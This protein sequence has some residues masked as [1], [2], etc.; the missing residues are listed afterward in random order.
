MQGREHLVH[1]ANGATDDLHAS[2]L[3]L[4]QLPNVLLDAVVIGHKLLHEIRQT[5]TLAL[6]PLHVLL[7]VRLVLNL[8]RQAP[9][10]LSDLLVLELPSP[11]FRID[12]RG[13]CL[14]ALHPRLEGEE[15]RTEG[16]TLTLE[17]RRGPLH[18]QEPLVLASEVAQ[19]LL[20][21][22]EALLQPRLLRSN[23]LGALLIDLPE[24]LL[25]GLVFPAVDELDVVLVQAPQQ[26]VVLLVG[27]LTLQGCLTLSDRCDEALADPDQ[28]CEPIQDG[29]QLRPS[30]RAADR[31]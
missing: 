26:D 6:Q 30:V 19:S 3:L 16:P 23:A 4:L 29:Q 8:L 5:S 18:L 2:G 11:L 10:R 17:Q 21:G 14:D 15:G 13:L 25:V 20:H 22:G 31:L 9:R 1:L 7:G 12:V 28:H 27:A 24:L